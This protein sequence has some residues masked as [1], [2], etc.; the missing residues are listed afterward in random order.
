MVMK[1]EKKVMLSIMAI[2]LLGL[3]TIGSYSIL[4]D[5]NNVR[6]LEKSIELI[7]NTEEK[8]NR[9][10]NGNSV[11]CKLYLPLVKIEDIKPESIIYYSFEGKY[12]PAFTVSE[13]N[14][15]KF[16]VI[17]ISNSKK[18][19]IEIEEFIKYNGEN[20]DYKYFFSME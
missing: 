11:S 5:N 14:N 13:I 6:N 12:Y 18:Q 2:S 19:W 17:N 3:I 16:S 8:S 10:Y 7:E 20:K 4:A 1:K 9:L 15:K